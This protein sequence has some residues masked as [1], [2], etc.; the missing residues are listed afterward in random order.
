MVEELHDVARLDAD[1]VVGRVRVAVGLAAAAQ[2]EAD[3]TMAVAA[4]G[5]ELVEV[6]A[7][8]GEAGEAEEGEALPFVGVGEG[9]AVGGGEALHSRYSG[10]AMPR[11]WKPPSTKIT[12]PVVQAPRSEAR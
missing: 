12:S 11:T 7:V 6:G 3:Q 9:E 10:C 4:G 2:G 1:V 5:G 8:A